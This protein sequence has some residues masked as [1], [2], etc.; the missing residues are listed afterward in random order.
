MKKFTGDIQAWSKEFLQTYK[1][2]LKRMKVVSTE[3]NGNT[4]IIVTQNLS[5]ESSS[6]GKWSFY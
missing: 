2:Q 4:L 6:I 1:D 5:G 3:I